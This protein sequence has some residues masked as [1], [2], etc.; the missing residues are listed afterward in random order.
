[1]ERCLQAK[2]LNCS[3]FARI[4]AWAPRACFVRPGYDPDICSNPRGS[5]KAFFSV[6]CCGT[7]GTVHGPQMKHRDAAYEEIGSGRYWSCHRYGRDIESPFVRLRS[8]A[9]SRW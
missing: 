1:M 5:A 2:N 3:Q 8:R 6:Y 9:L 7:G 4:F